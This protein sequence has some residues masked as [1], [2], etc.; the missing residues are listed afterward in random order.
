MERPRRLRKATSRKLRLSRGVGRA[1]RTPKYQ[2]STKNSS[3]ML[4]TN[5]M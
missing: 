4:R 2:N 3:G 1:A 5:S